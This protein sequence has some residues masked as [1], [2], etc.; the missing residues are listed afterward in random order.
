VPASS[1]VNFDLV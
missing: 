1:H